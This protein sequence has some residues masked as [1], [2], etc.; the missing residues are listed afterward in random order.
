MTRLLRYNALMSH[1]TP[2]QFRLKAEACR[3]LADLA[4][5]VERRKLWLNRAADWD[6][7]AVKAEKN[8]RRWR[9]PTA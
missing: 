2:A 4:D 3:R 8:N 1:E 7:M 5:N 6:D 9:P